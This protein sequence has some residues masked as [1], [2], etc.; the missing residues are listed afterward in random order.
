MI[1]CDLFKNQQQWLSL[2]AAPAAVIKCHVL[3]MDR[4]TADSR[5]RQTDRQT[6]VK[7]PALGE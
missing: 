5:N 1:N 6:R 2:T 7:R 4:Q 3:S